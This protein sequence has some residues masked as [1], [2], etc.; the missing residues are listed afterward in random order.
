MRSTAPEKYNVRQ[1]INMKEIPTDT[2]QVVREGVERACKEFSARIAPLGFT[3]TK[4]V[5]WIR[6]NPYTV[7]FIHLHRSGST[8]G[9]PI[10]YSVDFRIHFAIRVLNDTFEAPA[11]NGPFSDA[12]RLRE[13]R[14]HLRFNA[15]TSSTY[16]RC[17][18]DLARFV[19]EQGEPWFSKF[20]NCEMLLASS[21]S[22]LREADKERLQ[23]ALNGQSDPEV[24]SA[25]L[26]MLGIKGN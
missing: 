1:A 17:I 24:V 23:S 26:K 25:S 12:G 9:K 16:D 5:F 11:L 15:Q 2:T 3:R 20:R 8:Y 19:S 10:N 14:Y 13:G 21:D 7:E 6:R 22:P 18:D 4:K